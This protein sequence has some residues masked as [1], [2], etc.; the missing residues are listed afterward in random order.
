ML[1]GKLPKHLREK[2]VHLDV[3]RYNMATSCVVCGAMHVGSKNGVSH[4]V[5]CQSQVSSGKSEK[6]CYSPTQP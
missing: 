2:V 6:R 5:R 3:A 4:D 1:P